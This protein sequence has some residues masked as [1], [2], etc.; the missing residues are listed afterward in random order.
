MCEWDPKWRD[1]NGHHSLILHSKESAAVTSNCSSFCKRKS[2]HFE[3][4]SQQPEDPQESN[5]GL[6]VSQPR[7]QISQKDPT[8]TTWTHAKL[9]FYFTSSR[10]EL[11]VDVRVRQQQWG[12]IMSGWGQIRWADISIP[13][14]QPLSSVIV[15]FFRH[16]GKGMGRA[17]GA[18]HWSWEK[19][20]SLDTSKSW[21]IKPQPSDW[22]KPHSY[23]SLAL[24]LLKAFFG[25]MICHHVSATSL[26]HT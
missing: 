24:F 7:R 8:T 1:Q 5:G 19:V 16:E 13:P 21:Q 14:L 10:T 22:K 20:Q 15:F 25:L 23:F 26:D 6:K 4:C 12:E 2:V 18:W 17:R 9:P 3:L 11:W